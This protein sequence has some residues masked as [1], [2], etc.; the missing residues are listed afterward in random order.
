MRFS[1]M[2]NPDPLQPAAGRFDGVVHVF[3]VR[4]YYE[5]TD[6]SGRVYHASYLR[7]MER[8]R[9]EFLR[10]ANVHHGRLLKA[11]VPLVWTVRRMK[12]D[13]LGS[14]RMD[15][16]LQIRTRVM[17]LGGVRLGLAQS[18]VRD[19]KELVKAHIEVCLI[20][21]D[22]RVRRVPDAVWRKLQNFATP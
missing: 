8:G 22:G 4:V 10:D 12:I 6:F 3:W 11:D 18:V 17:E 7:F 2:T 20:T 9:T 21:L 13:F 5:D 15:D 1:V 14:A 19:A 16:A